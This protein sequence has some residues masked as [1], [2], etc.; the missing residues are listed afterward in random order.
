MLV[1]QCFCVATE[2]SVNKD[3]YKAIG[4]RKGVGQA[5]QL[6]RMA[7][8]RRSEF[9]RLRTLPASQAVSA[10]GYGCDRETIDFGASV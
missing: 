3:L 1:L 7:D 2:F 4:S 8:R 10:N 6:N 9:R 5:D